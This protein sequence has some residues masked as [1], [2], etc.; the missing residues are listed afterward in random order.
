MRGVEVSGLQQVLLRSVPSFLLR[1]NNMWVFSKYKLPKQRLM[2][3]FILL[4]SAFAVVQVTDDA[5]WDR[6]AT[7]KSS[8]SKDSEASGGKRI[9]YWLATFDM[10]E[11]Y[12]L[13]VGIY[14]FQTLST[15]YL[16][17]ERFFDTHKH[18]GEKIRAVHSTWFQAL[19]EIGWIGFF[20]FI[21]L[22]YKLWSR[23]KYTKNVLI[24]QGSYHNY[25]LVVAVQAGLIAFL[26]A[27]TFI[28]AFRQV[29]LYWFIAFCIAAS[30]IFNP[31][32]KKEA[33]KAP[34]KGKENL[35]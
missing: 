14:G 20:I 21:T 18:G 6:M 11:D 16:T 35:A 13:G 8:A 23:L 24:N 2:V 7:I 9:N 34:T 33:K 22:L 17:E 4:S 27:G 31:E 32:N 29:I 15:Q 10:L 25:Y 1:L 28:D 30:L 19:S 5:F 26:V 3:A 12:P